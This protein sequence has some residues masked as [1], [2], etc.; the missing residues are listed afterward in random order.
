MSFGTDT[1]QIFLLHSGRPVSRTQG[2]HFSFFDGG[3]ILTDFLR[4]GQIWKK[5]VQKHKKIAIFQIQGGEKCLPPLPPPQKEFP[6]RKYSERCIR[7]TY[8]CCYRMKDWEREEGHQSFVRNNILISGQFVNVFDHCLHN[9]NV[10]WASM[11]RRSAT[12][13]DNSLRTP[14]E[15]STCL[16]QHRELQTVSKLTKPVYLT[17]LRCAS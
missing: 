3:K 14:T 5:C 17:D 1:R 12:T 8:H 2:R 15:R 13:R 7:R 11:K 10:N 4:G 6:G 16:L 9:A